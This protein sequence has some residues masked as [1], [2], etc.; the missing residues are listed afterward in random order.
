MRLH[1]KG[2]TQVE[3]ANVLDVD[4]STIS[5]DL[6]CIKERSR[7]YSEQYVTKGIREFD[8]CLAG[9]DQITKNLWEISEDTN[10]DITTNKDKMA[11]LSML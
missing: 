10:I 11:A 9:L 1:S 8:R 4:Q 5:M 2:I 6:R 3:I 7:K